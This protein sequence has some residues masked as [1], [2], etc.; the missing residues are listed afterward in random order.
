VEKKFSKT[1]HSRSKPVE[2]QGFSSTER[3]EYEAYCPHFPSCVGCP[4][5]KVPYPEQLLKK[6][7][8]VGRALAEY[9]SLGGADVSPVVP[10]PQRLGYRARVKLVVRKNRDQVAMGLYVP[11]THRVIDISSC[12]VHPRQVNQ[13]VFYL[14]KK[15]LELGIAPY[16]ERDDSGDLRYVDFRF[17]V[18]RHELSL[19]LVTRHASFPQGAPLAKALQQR[20]PFI[21]GVIQNVNENRGNVIWG[22]SFRTLGGRDTIMER[23]GDLK[24][25]FPAGVFSQ[26][27]PF[28]ARKL[29]DRVYE[30]AALKGGETVLDLYCGVG[31]ISLY[32]AVAA[33]QV[34]AVD[35]SELSITTAKQ[36]ARR[37]GRGNCRFIA[38][39]VAT[40][41]TQLTK[42]LPRIDLM[43]LNP[44]R[45]GIKAAALESVLAA[46]APRI[47][48]VSCEPRSLARDLDRLVA[49]NYRVEQIQPFDMFPQTEEVETLVLLRKNDATAN[50]SLHGYK[51][52]AS[53]S[54]SR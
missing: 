17:S 25:V 45:K 44:P 39:D 31:P 50:Q 46:G 10:S 3:A 1:S 34:W 9:F 51:D 30:L 23:V 47:I 21:T 53:E 41:L 29:Y 49:A 27:N 52:A 36:N 28:T 7:A 8:I 4:F 5:I 22:N 11:Q 19:T 12:P 54:K 43:V 6:R 48:Y 35:D 33:R 20:F 16:D 14:K 18:A 40:T 15:V 32:L 13:V 42:D 26:A 24:L 2:R 38:G 37:N